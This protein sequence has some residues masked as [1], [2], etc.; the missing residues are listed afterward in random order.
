MRLRQSTTIMDV[1]LAFS[2]GE[3]PKSGGKF[4]FSRKCS[5]TLHLPTK[6]IFIKPTDKLVHPTPTYGF[7]I[8]GKPSNFLY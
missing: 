3:K 7:C 1:T 5:T 2:E 6:C 4:S 8:P